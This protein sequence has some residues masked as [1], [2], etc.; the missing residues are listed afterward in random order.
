L[1]DEWQ[2]AMS[3]RDLAVVNL[4]TWPFCKKYGYPLSPNE[5]ERRDTGK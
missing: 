4:M 5:G 3:R 1:D 2:T